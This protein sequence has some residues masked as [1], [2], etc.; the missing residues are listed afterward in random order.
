MGRFHLSFCDIL[1][2]LRF[3]GFAKNTVKITSYLLYLDFHFQ[4]AVS[5]LTLDY[6][7]QQ[8]KLCY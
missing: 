3:G 4:E 6:V 7:G 2:N 1:N 8:N 5:D